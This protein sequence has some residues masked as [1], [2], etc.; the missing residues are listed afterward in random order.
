MGCP[1]AT[2]REDLSP[3]ASQGRRFESVRASFALQ[4]LQSIGGRPPVDHEQRRPSIQMRV[5]DFGNVD[6]KPVAVVSRRGSGNGRSPG[7]L[8][9][10]RPLRLGAFDRVDGGAVQRD[11]GSLRRSAPFLECAI[12]PKES[13]P[14]SKTNSIPE[15]RGEPS[16][17]KVAIVLCL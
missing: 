1:G 3:V 7:D 13:S 15:I 10:T 12:E 17:R 11:R 16:A 14:S 4:P 2:Q 5:D 9:L 6:A 8:R